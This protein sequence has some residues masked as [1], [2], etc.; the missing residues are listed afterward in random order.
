[1][2]DNALELTLLRAPASPEMRADN[3]VHHFTYAFT[4]FEGPFVHS[5]LVSQGYDLNVPARV[6]S[7]SLPDAMQGRMSLVTLEPS[8]VYLDTLKLAE[9]GSGDLFLRFYEAMKSSVTARIHTAF[10]GRAWRCDMLENKQKELAFADGTLV[11][12]FH[13]FEIVTLRIREE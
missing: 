10:R 7:G 3:H 1:M 13:P 8:D 6:L 12:P 4:A 2:N 5:D 11:V 9:D